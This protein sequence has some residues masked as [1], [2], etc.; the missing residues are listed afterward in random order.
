[1]ENENI[2]A[3][4]KRNIP[5]D[6]F[7]HLL[8]IV[9]L[10]W[11]AISFVS[12][13]WQFINNFFP[14]VLDYYQ[15]SYSL[16]LIRFSVSAI[17]IVF[18][19][20]IVI[21]WYLNKIY[22]KVAAV[23]ESKIRKWLL[24]LTLFISSLV[25]IGDLIF[26]I[27]TFLGGE[28]TT[29]FILKALSVILVAGVVFGYYLDDVRRDTPTK[30]AKYFA[31][32]TSVLVLAVVVGAFFVVGSPNSA[33]LVQFDQQKIGDLQNIQGQIVNYWQR[34]EALLGS[35]TDLNDPISSFKVPV[36]P[37]TEAVYEYNI[38]DAAN[39]SFELCATFNKENREPDYQ[40][41]IAKPIPP[42]GGIYSQNW[43]HL[44][45]R[46]FFERTIDKHLYPP[47]NKT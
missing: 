45:G 28:I 44:E 31:W 46:V 35:L 10:Y 47:L 42:N 13:I 38:K 21:S 12:L 43:D 9:T 33:R 8:A 23:R 11:S 5:R 15:T 30:L 4:P 3:M 6:L 19:V 37:Q 29:R 16:G 20:F 40:G 7:L 34:K 2:G 14:D 1:M 24:Y 41:R 26:V 17:I 18:P 36:D 22:T 39:L 25:I 32:G 27:N